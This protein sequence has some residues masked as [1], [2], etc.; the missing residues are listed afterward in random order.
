MVED[1]PLYR[2]HVHIYTTTRRHI[3][4]ERTIDIAVR[5]TN[6]VSDLNYFVLCKLV[7]VSPTVRPPQWA[8]GKFIVQ[9]KGLSITHCTETVSDDTLRHVR[10]DCLRLH[11]KHLP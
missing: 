9:Q 11:L 4:E 10:D 6:T 8:S 5:T 7:C 1:F 2:W 3:P